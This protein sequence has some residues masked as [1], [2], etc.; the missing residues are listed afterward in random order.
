MEKKGASS[1]QDADHAGVAV[2]E[3][4]HR[5][6]QVRDQ[7]CAG[8]HRV[9]R[10]VDVRRRVAHRHHH[11]VVV[12]VLDRLQRALQFRRDRHQLHVLQAAVARQ[13]RLLALRRRLDVLLR[14][15]ARAVLRDERA[16]RVHAQDG[17]TVQHRALLR[18]EDGQQLLVG[19]GVGGDD[20]RADRRAARLRLTPSHRHYGHQVARHVVHLLDGHVRVGEVDS[21]ASVDLDVD[22]PGNDDQSLRIDDLRSDCRRPSA[23]HRG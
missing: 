10:R 8:A 14:V 4:R 23:L 11:A 22:V 9:D 1:S 16:L 19:G 3:R 12:Q 6:E 2:V 17:R 13:D 15:R 7:R 5:V 18:L 20:R 21:V